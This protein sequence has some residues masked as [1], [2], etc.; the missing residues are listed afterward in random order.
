[1][2]EQQTELFGPTSGLHARPRP[3]YQRHSP[4]SRDAADKMRSKAVSLRDL[5][6]NLLIEAGTHGATDEEIYRRL[7]DTNKISATTKDSTIRAR[8]IELT[9]PECGLVLDSGNE[10]RTAAGVTATVWVYAYAEANAA[11][12]ARERLDGGAA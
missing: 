2:A 8:R 5:V 9:R 10:R 7:I 1:M 6:F 11:R 4:A 3:P 12:A